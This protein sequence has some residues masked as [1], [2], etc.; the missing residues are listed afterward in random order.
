MLQNLPNIWNT[1]IHEKL[2]EKKQSEGASVI[3]FCKIVLLNK[4]VYILNKVEQH[5]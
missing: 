5:Y 2:L 1:E 4:E 3:F